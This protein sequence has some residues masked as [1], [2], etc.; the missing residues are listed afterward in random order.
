[1]IINLF[2]ISFVLSTIIRLICA[3]EKRFM[4]RDE[5]LLKLYIYAYV[6]VL[7]LNYYNILI[8]QGAEVASV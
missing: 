1:M 7:S 4:K 6:Y 5:G 8:A 2:E 3:V